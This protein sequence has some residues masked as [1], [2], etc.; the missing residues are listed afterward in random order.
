M[1]SI[2]LLM[3]STQ[4]EEYDMVIW[5]PSLFAELMGRKIF[6]IIIC[7]CWQVRGLLFGLRKEIN[8]I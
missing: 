6:Q 2:Y 7:M 8:K 4:H 1:I 3:P 5:V